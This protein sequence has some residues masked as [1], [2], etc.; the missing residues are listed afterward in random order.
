MNQKVIQ[1][2]AWRSKATTRGL[3]AEEVYEALEQIREAEGGRLSPE[4]VVQAA[5]AKKHI[6]HSF[7]EWDDRRAAEIG[8][9]AQARVLL[10][11]IKVF[12]EVEESEPVKVNAF[13]S[14]KR[15][16]DDDDSSANERGYQAVVEVLQSPV[17]RQ[18]LLR[19][20][21]DQLQFWRRKYAAL[22]ELGKIFEAIDETLKGLAKTRH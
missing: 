22:N 21:L 2:V 8:R 12:V 6:L 17:G 5:K 15:D 20:A 10:T 14:M 11:D 1:R 16:L 13:V 4:A 19:D 3:S 7:F 9:L 18:A